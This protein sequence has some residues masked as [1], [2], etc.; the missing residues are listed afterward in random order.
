MDALQPHSDPDARN[1]RHL[2]RIVIAAGGEPR[3]APD[4]WPDGSWSSDIE[5]TSSPATGG[6]VLR[7]GPASE[8]RGNLR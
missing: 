3:I 4:Q 1:I 7:V 8:S 2:L 5:I 6:I